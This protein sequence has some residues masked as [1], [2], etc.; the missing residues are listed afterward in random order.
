[1]IRGIERRKIFH[2][3]GDRQDLLDRLPTLPPE[4]GT[5]C[6]T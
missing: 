4:T 6:Y 5:I 1:M 3:N 2:E